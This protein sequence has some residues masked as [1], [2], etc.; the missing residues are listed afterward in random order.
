M[1]NPNQIHVRREEVVVS[2]KDLL[3]LEGLKGAITEKVSPHE[4]DFEK[5]EL[6]YWKHK[7]HVKQSAGMMLRIRVA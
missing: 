1:P 6:A 5:Q 2:A 4:I 7:P 3:S